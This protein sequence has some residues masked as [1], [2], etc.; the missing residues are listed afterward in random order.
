MIRWI[1]A[2]LMLILASV[3]LLAQ[4]NVPANADGVITD[5]EVMDVAEH[6]FCPICENE[7]LDESSGPARAR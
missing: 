2:L 3:P 6:M 1:A 7:P 4:D 5:D